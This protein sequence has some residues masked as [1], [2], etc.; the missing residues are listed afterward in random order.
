MRQDRDFRAHR[1][2]RRLASPNMFLFENCEV[3]SLSRRVELEATLFFGMSVKE[4]VSIVATQA[5]LKIDYC[6]NVLFRK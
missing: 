4:N 3:F 1:Q 2:K 5:R 6:T